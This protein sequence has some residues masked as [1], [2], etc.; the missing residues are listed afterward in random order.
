MTFL[1]SSP[2]QAGA[3]LFFVTNLDSRLRGNERIVG[4]ACMFAVRPV[5][6]LLHGALGG[7]RSGSPLK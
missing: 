4:E 5:R 2:A 7:R 3:Q 6:L 1:R